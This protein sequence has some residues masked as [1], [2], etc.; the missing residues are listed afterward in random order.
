MSNTRSTR[1]QELPSNSQIKAAAEEFGGFSESRP[2]GEQWES[3]CS[4]VRKIVKAQVAD[5]TPDDR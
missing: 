2:L 3:I 4:L 1:Q 5:R